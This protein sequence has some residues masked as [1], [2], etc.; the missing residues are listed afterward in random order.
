[1]KRVDLAEKNF[2]SSGW[3]ALPDLAEKAKKVA[4]QQSGVA[5]TKV[6]NNFMLLEKVKKGKHQIMAVTQ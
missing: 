1:M 3:L 4:V 5:K 2:G 6:R